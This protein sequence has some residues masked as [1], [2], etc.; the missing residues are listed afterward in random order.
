MTGG[1][2]QLTKRWTAGK[3]TADKNG[4]VVY[5]ILLQGK[6]KQICYLWGKSRIFMS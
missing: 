2:I 6:L 1:Q 4:N 5:F 3:T